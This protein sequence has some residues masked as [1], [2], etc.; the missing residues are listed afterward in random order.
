MENVFGIAS[1]GKG[2]VVAITTSNVR[3]A[4]EKYG[5]RQEENEIK[6]FVV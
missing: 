2:K 1:E 6:E 5:L 3:V 4:I